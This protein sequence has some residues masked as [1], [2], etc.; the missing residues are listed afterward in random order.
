MHYG[1]SKIRLLKTLIYDFYFWMQILFF[2]NL[3][4]TFLHYLSAGTWYQD[5]I[6]DYV[7]LSWHAMDIKWNG[8]SLYDKVDPL[9]DY[10]SAYK[11]NFYFMWS[12]QFSNDSLFKTWEK[13]EYGKVRIGFMGLL[14][15]FC[16]CLWDFICALTCSSLK[17]TK[18][19]WFRN[20]LGFILLCFYLYKFSKITNQRVLEWQAEIKNISEVVYLDKLFSF[21]I[22]KWRFYF[23]AISKRRR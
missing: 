9:A 20:L 16:L 21:L 6:S 13:G 2:N 4:S 22:L 3:S 5:V 12:F 23:N 11:E 10:H 7:P 1:F 8:F 19:Y 15:N 17:L 14:W 18:I